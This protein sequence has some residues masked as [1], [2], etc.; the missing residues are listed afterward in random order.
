MIRRPP[1]STLFPYTTL[2]RS[3]LFWWHFVCAQIL[4]AHVCAGSDS[5]KLSSVLARARVFAG[6]RRG[7]MRPSRFL[8]FLSVF[9]VT[10]LTA[11]CPAYVSSNSA[12]NGRP[13]IT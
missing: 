6:T 2:F 5:G 13:S 7:G 11:G 12:S 8:L 1:R 3:H 9:L 4:V 10:H